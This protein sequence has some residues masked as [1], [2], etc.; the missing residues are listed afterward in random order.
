MMEWQSSKLV[1]TY[2]GIW[3]SSDTSANEDNLFQNHIRYLKCD[4]PYVSIEN[5]LIRS[6]C[7]PL[8]K[9]KVYKIVKSTL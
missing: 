3:N 2:E 1:T 7:C 8:F 4:F 9:D 5:R 6:G